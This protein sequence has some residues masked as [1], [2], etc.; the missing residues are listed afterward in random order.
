M[1]WLAMALI[2]FAGVVVG[3]AGM[4]SYSNSAGEAA[5]APARWPASTTL[6]RDP[7]RPTIVM[8]AHPQCDCTRASLMELAKVLARAP[9]KAHA[10]V[11][12][13]MPNGVDESWE[14]TSI[15]R[16]ASQI[17]GVTILRDKDGKEAS[18]FGVA[19]SGQT[20]MYDGSGRLVFSGGTTAA[21]GH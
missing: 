13:M 9:G 17:P 6:R 8:L 11:V 10:L 2:W 20:L 5:Q 7:T 3:L 12:F 16:L 14:H 4:A 19:T 21:R 18:R 15:W 1:L